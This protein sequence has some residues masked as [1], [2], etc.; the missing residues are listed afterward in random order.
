LQLLR[1]MPR[2]FEGQF[3][4]RWRVGVDTEARLDKSE[5][6]YGNITHL[7]FLDGPLSRVRILIEGEVD[8]VDTN[9]QVRGSIERQPARLFL[10][11]TALT[12]ASPAL[13]R[14]ARET[15]A[16]QGGE[17]LATLHT[18]TARIYRDMEFRVGATTAATSAAEAFK[19]QA[20]VCQDFAHVLIAAARSLGV[21]ARYV[22]GY[23]LRTDRTDQEA[24]HAWMEA[25]L[26]ALGWIGFD[27]AQGLCV[28]DRYVRVAIGCDA[29]DAAPVRGAQFGGHDESL[30]VSILVEQGRAIAQD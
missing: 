23:Y 21:P 27:P 30:D 13:L 19:A 26:P 6:A 25:H 1:L 9:G 29:R 12:C 14:L 22:S 8:T 28:S 18:L 2:P 5:D 16:A 4:R 3:I 15:R 17:L 11:E 20:G 24:G 7:V 10:R